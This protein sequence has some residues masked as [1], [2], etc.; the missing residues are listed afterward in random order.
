MPNVAPELATSL[1]KMC[2]VGPAACEAAL[3][4]NGGNLDKALR[5]LIASG[6]ATMDKLDPEL[7]SDEH[8][9]RAEVKR[10]LT[11]GEAMPD[12]N[13]AILQTLRRMMSGKLWP[14][15]LMKGRQAR[16]KALARR[17]G[18]GPRQPG[19]RERRPKPS[20]LKLPP[21]PALRPDVDEWTGRDVLPSWKG[22]DARGGS[23][24]SR[25][26]SRATGRVE[27]R[28]I[29]PPGKGDA[30]PPAPQ[31]VEAYRYLKDNE[32]DVTDAV[33]TAVF[34]QYPKLRKRY[35]FGDDD[36]QDDQY[37]PVIK[38]RRELSKLI[39]LDTVHVLNIARA[40]QAYVG[41][42][43]RCSWDDEHDLGV[44]THKGRVVEIG[45]ADTAFDVH[46][47][48]KDGGKAIKL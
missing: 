40:E 26:G 44:L 41:F 4:A 22:F 7:T 14:E 34:K 30:A 13:P 16:A 8:Y 37:M 24:G 21:L 5:A 28:V 18:K 25:V 33:V 17:K 31:Q 48:R 46:A 47:A 6:E 42:Q 1:G 32:A 27:V 29:P 10:N 3:R 19:P 35:R 43:C 12:I 15:W 38:D 9:A 45:H 2:G 39:R 23:N 11:L 36:Y 20:G